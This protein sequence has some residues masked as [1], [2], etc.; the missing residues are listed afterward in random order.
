MLAVK[1]NNTELTDATTSKEKISEDKTTK[2]PSTF[3]YEN[4]SRCD[5]PRVQKPE[6]S[7]SSVPDL[8]SLSRANRHRSAR[9]GDSVLDV[10]PE[11]VGDLFPV[12]YTHLTLPTNREV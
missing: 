4:A 10:D 12:S 5:L 2:T 3:T 8:R 9:S 6:I 11:S 7:A 1:G